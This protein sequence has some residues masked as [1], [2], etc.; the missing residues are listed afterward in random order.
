[1]AQSTKLKREYEFEAK[2]IDKATDEVVA[3]I[4]GCDEEDLEGEMGKSKWTKAIEQFE[5]RSDIKREMILQD[6]G[7]SESDVH[8]DEDAREFIYGEIEGGDDKVEV[9]YRK[10]YLD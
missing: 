1:M 6:Y 8:E 5:N 9:T 2:I 7:M 4:S 3:M 10:V